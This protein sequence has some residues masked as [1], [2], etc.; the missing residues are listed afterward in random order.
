MEG[1]VKEER[2]RGGKRRKKGNISK[3]VK[4][5]H[6]R[7]TEGIERNVKQGWEK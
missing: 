7:R 6:W 1:K 2:K 3:K 5:R 4:V